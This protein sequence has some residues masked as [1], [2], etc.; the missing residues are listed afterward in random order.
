MLQIKKDDFDETPDDIL[1]TINQMLNQKTENESK[2][3]E[4]NKKEGK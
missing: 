3:K 4:E 1:K 2:K